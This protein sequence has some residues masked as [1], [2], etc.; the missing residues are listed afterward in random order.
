MNMYIHELRAYRKSTI[1]WTLSMVAVIMVF[2]SLYPSITDD[3]TAFKKVLESYPQPVLKA[4]GIAVDYITSFLGFYSY[5]FMYI[6][7]CGSIQAMNYGTSVISKE[8]REKTAD[9]LLTKPVTRK[10]I[11][12]SKLLAVLSSIL[13]TNIIYLVCS[14]FIARAVSK[15]SIDFKLF[16]MISITLLFVQLMFFALGVL[17]SV[18]LP[19][20]RSVLSVSLSVVLGLFTL[21]MFSSV[22]GE[23][24]VRYFTPFKYYDAA[25]I[26]K[27][28]SYETS[29]IVTE[30]VFVVLSVLLSLFIY[31]KKDIHAV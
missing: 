15:D 18:I 10:Q 16:Y 7:L 19:K 21:N 4:F 5:I 6:V 31:R 27:N 22:L 17:V 9:F 26:I 14:T 29:F 11:Y 13:I 30:I 25:Y 1:A 24:T 23:E 28:A 8:V 12:V 2:L 20:V 3:A